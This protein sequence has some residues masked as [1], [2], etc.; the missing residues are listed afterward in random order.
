M[1]FVVVLY[2]DYILTFQEEVTYIWCQRFRISTILYIM[3]RYALIANIVYL[4]ALADKLSVRVVQAATMAMLY[5]RNQTVGLVLG[6][7]AIATL[8]ADIAKLIYQPRGVLA[9]FMCIFEV[10]S[11][12]LTIVRIVQAMKAVGPWRLQKASLNY[13]LFE[14][15]LL[16]IIS[17]TTLSVAALTLNYQREIGFIQRLLNGLKLPISGLMTARFLLHLR[18]WDYNRSRPSH[19]S[20]H[21]TDIESGAP[22]EP[23]SFAEE[24][25][26]VPMQVV[27]EAARDDTTTGVDM[28]SPVIIAFVRSPTLRVRQK[29][30]TPTSFPVAGPSS[31]QLR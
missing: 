20:I 5:S 30:Q 11:A 2:Y 21:A 12:I 18:R 1:T 9:I 28:E 3:C 10:T 16:Y 22:I 15:G 25:G 7:M 31:R 14:Q 19:I 27:R 29:P 8:C 24:F 13:L 23:Q 26:E 6:V 4:F 17:V